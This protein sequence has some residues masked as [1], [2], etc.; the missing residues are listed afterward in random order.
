MRT[1]RRAAVV[2]A[3]WAGAPAAAEDG[4]TVELNRL[5]PAEAGCRAYLVV[6]NGGDALSS[7]NLDLVAFDGAGLILSRL[8]V[9]AGPLRARRPTVTAFAIPGVACDA[10]ARVL[11]NDVLACGEAEPASCFARMTARSRGG[12][13]LIL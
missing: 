12:A 11:V 6:E 8:A 4:L 13:E 1:M 9:E 10:I 3:L 5:E 2:L 7:L